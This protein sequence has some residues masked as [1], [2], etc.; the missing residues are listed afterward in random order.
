MAGCLIQQRFPAIF[1]SASIPT[2]DRP[3]RYFETADVIAIRDCIKALVAAA[4][5]KFTLVWG[6]HPSIT[7]MIRLLAEASYEDISDHFILYQSSEFKNIAPKDNDYFKNIVWVDGTLDVRESLHLLRQQMFRDLAYAAAVFIGGMEG[8]E[9]EFK[10]FREIHPEIPVFPVATTGG[11]AKFVY[12]EWA[13][14]LSLPAALG[15]EVAYPFMW[16]E[17]LS[18][19][20]D[21]GESKWRF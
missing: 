21:F 12:Q 11:A 19:L 10:Q 9:N 14:E 2:P 18:S 7:P 15:D 1:L 3:G 13:L 20:S 6:G 8:I 4:A 17:L 16:R 5:P